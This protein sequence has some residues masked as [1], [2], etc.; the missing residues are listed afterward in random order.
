VLRAVAWGAYAAFALAL[1]VALALAMVAPVARSA[2]LVDE[3]WVGGYDHSFNNSG[4]RREAGTAEVE[5]EAD[6]AELQALRMLG[7]PRLA[8]T[9][10]VNTGGKT[11]FGG[12]AFNWR[13]QIWRRLYAGVQLGL[14]ANDGY[15]RITPGYSNETLR[16]DRLQLGS[17]VLFREAASLGCRLDANWSAG[18]QY[19]HNSTGEILSKGPNESLNELGVNVGRRFR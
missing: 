8:L 6:T 4:G 16:R 1:V 5:V 17:R 2:E 15:T 11:D 18:L 19:I 13:R 3:V 9:M 12:A 7:A 10:A 14:D